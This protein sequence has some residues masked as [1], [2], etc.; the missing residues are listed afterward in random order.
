MSRGKN[1]KWE[2]GMRKWECFEVGSRDAAFDKLRR[3]KVGKNWKWE[4]GM[5]PSTSSDEAKW[6]SPEMG[7]RNLE[8]G[9]FI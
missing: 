4:V 7:I 1:W 5:R 3:G 6:E 2:V 9:N 8:N